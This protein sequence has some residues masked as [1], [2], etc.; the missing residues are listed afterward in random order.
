MS[1]V[2]PTLSWNNDVIRLHRTSEPPVCVDLGA[3]LFSYLASHFQAAPSDTRTSRGDGMELV[4]QKN[5]FGADWWQRP[6]ERGREE[7]NE[8]NAAADY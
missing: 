1:P 6:R 8:T 3:S 5:Q 2:A 4:W 7:N